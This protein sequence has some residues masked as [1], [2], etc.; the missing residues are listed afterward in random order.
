MGAFEGEAFSGKALIGEAFLGEALLGEALL[1]E[2]RVG[3]TSLYPLSLVLTHALLA[4]ATACCNGVVSFFF[5]M[6]FPT[7]TSRSLTIILP[8]SSP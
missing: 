7:H 5:P 6:F 1:G 2:T 4:S 8:P 3:N